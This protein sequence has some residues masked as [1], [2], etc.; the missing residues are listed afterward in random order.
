MANGL[1]SVKKKSSTKKV[2]K[3]PV[4]NEAFIRGKYN[5]DDHRKIGYTTAQ[6][7]NP[8]DTGE[9]GDENNEIPASDALALMG[10]A[11]MVMAQEKGISPD[12]IMADIYSMG[13][14][15][16]FEM[17]LYY[18]KEVHESDNVVIKRLIKKEQEIQ[19]LIYGTNAVKPKNTR[20]NT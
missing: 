14:S 8:N 5:L 4:I 11:I 18:K 2:I 1:K 10:N 16:C 19:E 3:K 17:N 20:K 9:Y 13:Y 6:L 12:K 15:G 7:N